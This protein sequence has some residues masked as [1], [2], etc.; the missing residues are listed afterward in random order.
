MT[1]QTKTNGKGGIP[2]HRRTRLFGMNNSLL[3]NTTVY[4]NPA[5]E[6]QAAVTL[7]KAALYAAAIKDFNESD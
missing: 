5:E 7:E 1:D 2:R 6:S 4:L 3:S